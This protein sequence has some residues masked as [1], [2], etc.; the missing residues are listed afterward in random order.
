MHSIQLPMKLDNLLDNINELIYSSEHYRF[1]WFPH[2]D[3]CVSWGANRVPVTPKKLTTVTRLNNFLHSR[4]EK[5]INVHLFELLLYISKFIPSLVPIVNILY[6]YMM[7]NRKI[8]VTDAGYKVCFYNHK[9]LI[10][11]NIGVWF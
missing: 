7:Y 6:F 11:L 4:W 2:T 10:V 9:I 8:E 5:L 3:Y 1:W